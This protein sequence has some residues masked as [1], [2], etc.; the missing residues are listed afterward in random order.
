MP[1]SEILNVV[2]PTFIAILV[3]YVIG[4]TIKIDLTGVI[5]IVF[6][7]GL[8][9]LA[10]VS[11]LS[12]QIVL[13]DAAKVWASALIVTFGCGAIA[14]VLFKLK[15]E[16]HSSLYLP[17]SLPNTVNIPFPIISLAY[18]SAG[19]SSRPFITFLIS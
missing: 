2:L 17:I 5:D 7:V 3:G 6:Y 14:W 11:I 9:A 4:R 12:Q 16:H 1:F 8:P 18:G 10:F 19:H 15:R 13:L